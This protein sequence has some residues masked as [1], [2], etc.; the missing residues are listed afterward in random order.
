M[1]DGITIVNF[2]TGEDPQPFC[3][4]NA[5][6]NEDGVVNLLDFIGTVNIIITGKK[7]SGVE[8]NSST[9]NLYLNRYGIE[10]E[11]DGTFSR[12]PDRT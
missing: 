9:A 7:S 3:F 2:V 4:E 1:L 12:N 11:S 8:I 10:L 6:V 5:D